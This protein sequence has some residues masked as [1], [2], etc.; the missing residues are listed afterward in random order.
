MFGMKLLIHV[1]LALVLLCSPTG[2]AGDESRVLSAMQEE[3][4]RSLDDLQLEGFE[5]PYF[6]AYSL[7]ELKHISMS[8]SYGAIESDRESDARYV[9]VDVHVGDYSFDN[10]PSGPEFFY[11]PDY[12]DRYARRLMHAPLENDM[13]ALR[14][15]LWLL[16]DGRYKQALDALNQKKGDLISKVEQEDRPDD[17]SREDPSVKIYPLKTLELDCEKWRGDLKSISATFKRY[18]EILTSSV[19]FSASLRNQ[20]MIN[21]EGSKLQLSD[22]YF[23]LSVEADARCD[24]GMSVYN[25]KT[26]KGAT[27][28]DLPTVSQ[29]REEVKQLIYDLLALRE[30]DPTEPYSGPAVIVNK[31]A[32][33][34]FHEALGH[35]LEGHRL[36]NEREGHTFKGKVGQKVI[37][38]FLSVVDDPLLKEFGGTPLYGHYEYDQEMVRAQRVVLVENGVLRGFL[39][40]RLP[41]KGF[42]QSNGHGRADIYS[43]PV[44]RMGNLIVSTEN[45]RSY[46]ELI[47]MLI[48][49]CIAQEKEYGL[50]FD[51]LS[52]GE[53]NTSGFGVQSLRCR[54]ILV[55]KI[56]V[57]DRRTEL[58]RGVE[59][60]G[61]PL[62]ILENVIA[63]A[64][65]PAV[66][67]GACTAESGTLAVSS[68]APSILISRLEVQKSTQQSRRPPILPPPLL[69]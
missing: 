9:S 25:V 46:D 17:F 56:F 69:E 33:V 32:G 53:T 23:S 43:K 8:A 54:P 13:D 2:L 22:Y 62:N 10:T 12:Y 24:D 15:R 4:L 40:S 6:I 60:I 55:R 38:E 1:S 16:T 65:D 14:H 30:A 64:N 42:P 67:N 37:P 58:V 59:L 44:S 7:N 29:L 66:F 26:W 3:M 61:T 18:P 11:M 28:A 35:R 34:F 47:D 27:L 50:I 49:E 41:A 5:K 21:S 68:V 57:D 19:S 63:A 39:M 51:V 20:F 36:R 52:S 48:D 45:P 31:A